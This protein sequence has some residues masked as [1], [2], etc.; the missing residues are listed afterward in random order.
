[1][2]RKAGSLSQRSCPGG[3]LAF[4][5]L[6]ILVSI[7]LPLPFIWLP[8]LFFIFLVLHPRAAPPGKATV[9]VRFSSGP[10]SLRSPPF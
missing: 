4:L 1:M 2:N 6:L 5:P 7:F 9:P 8:V 3:I 10:P